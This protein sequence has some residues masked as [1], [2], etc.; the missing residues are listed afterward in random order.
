MFRNARHQY[1]E[2]PIVGVANQFGQRLRLIGGVVG[3]NVGGDL[4]PFGQA[5]APID[6]AQRRHEFGPHRA[7]RGGPSAEIEGII[8]Q[9]R[10]E[11]AGAGLVPGLVVGVER[12]QRRQKSQLRVGRRVVRLR[13][14]PEAVFESLGMR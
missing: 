6:L 4:L 14:F 13:L 5:L 1:G 11:H 7:Q 8:G 12:G 10:I 9:P 3:Q 2:L